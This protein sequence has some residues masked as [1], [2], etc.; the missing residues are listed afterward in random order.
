M[1]RVLLFALLSACAPFLAAQ[2]YPAKTVRVV[3][4]YPPGG[5]AEAAARLLTMHLTQALGQ[6][7]VIDPKPG[8]N[9]LIGTEMVAKAP[10]DG[11]TLLFTG[12][13]TMSVQPFVFAGKLPYD[14]LNDFAPVSMVS[15]FPFFVVVPASLPAQSLAEFVALA[16]AKPGQVAYASNG[17][18]ALAHLGTEMLSRG[19]G[20]DMLHVPYKGF[21]PALPD[22][23]SGRVSLMMADWVVVAPHIKEG[24]LRALAVT[25]RGRWNSAPE[26]PTVAE[27]AIPGYAVDVWFALYAP[28]STPADVVA[29]LGAETRKYLASPEAKAAY[30]K[31][32][33]EAYGSP[34]E[35]VMALVRA[36]HAKYSV[37]VREAKVSAK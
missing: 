26:V 9:T 4:P 10:G 32:G 33:H 22:L 25:S 1:I 19:T 14:P 29:R 6:P 8:G 13:S 28:K 20:I 37:A 24:K 34:G 2:S 3:I 27:L 21:A 23:L 36:E 16:K 17:T 18:G 15:R 35:E 30:D 31:L 12:G 11:Y 7:F 5:G